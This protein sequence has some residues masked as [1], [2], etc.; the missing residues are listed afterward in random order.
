MWRLLLGTV[1][2]A[3]PRK[4]RAALRADEAVPWQRAAA[5]SGVLECLLGLAALVVW[6][7]H[8]VSTWAA[9]ALDSAL[10]GG[11][12]A[13]VPGQA[14]GF[15]ALVLWCLHPGTWLLAFFAVEGAV[16]MLAAVATEEV[17]GLS[18]LA[19]ADWCYGKAAGR[20]R[21]GDAL[22][23]PTGREQV[24]S[25]LATVR[26][27]VQ[28]AGLAELADEIALSGPGELFLEIRSC[29]PKDGWTPPRVVRFGEGYYRLETVSQGPRPRPFVFR[30]RRLEAGVPGRTVL[31]YR[32]PE[33]GPR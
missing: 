14:I 21:E 10:R 2:A 19:F 16:R 28:T 29:R 18:L 12:E 22:H 8:S 4:W 3:L 33:E 27:K 26:G 13:A 11:P 5:L 30:L 23:V 15:S 1:F 6:Y 17:R 20:E 7:S 25:L 31:V 9:N 32:G 24:A